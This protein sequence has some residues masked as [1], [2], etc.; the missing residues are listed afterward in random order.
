MLKKIKRLSLTYFSVVVIPFNR[1]EWKSLEYSKIRPNTVEFS[2][3]ENSLLKVKVDNSAS[4]LVYKLN[5]S[6]LV[7]SLSFKGKIIGKLNLQHKNQGEVGADDFAVKVGVVVEGKKTLNFVQKM[8]SPRWIKELYS[9]GGGNIGIDHI[10][11]FNISN[12][13]LNWQQRTHPLSNLIIENITGVKDSGDFDISY[14]FDK[15]LN[16]IAVW[17]SSDGDD[18]KSK[19]EIEFNEIKLEEIS[20]NN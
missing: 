13:K 1:G 4:P 12:T 6:L 15:P 18:T 8:I 19:Y 17:V 20:N 14:N 10:E 2:S 11:F 9:L 3:G 5:K 16:V 7:K